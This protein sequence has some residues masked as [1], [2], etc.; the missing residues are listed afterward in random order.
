MAETIGV[1]VEKRICLIAAKY[2]RSEK[3][4]EETTVF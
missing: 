1:S 2:R 3:N 4:S